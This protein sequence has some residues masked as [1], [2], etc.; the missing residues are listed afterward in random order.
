A[1]EQ[2]RAERRIGRKTGAA[3]AVD[4]RVREHVD[5]T[6]RRHAAKQERA[7]LA[8]PAQPDAVAQDDLPRLFT[9]HGGSE[10]RLAFLLGGAHTFEPAPE[11]AAER[12]TDGERRRQQSRRGAEQRTP[13]ELIVRAQGEETARGDEGDRLADERAYDQREGDVWNRAGERDRRANR[14]PAQQRARVQPGPERA[15]ERGASHRAE[16][17]EAGTG[18]HHRKRIFRQPIDADRPAPEERHAGGEED[19]RLR[20]QPD[21]FPRDRGERDGREPVGSRWPCGALIGSDS[22]QHVADD[23]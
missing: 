9:A 1:Q 4:Q 6:G 19:S 3:E 23:E 14:N 11:A 5:E 15:S 7:E 21:T 13:G 10:E 16:S 8:A 18:E 2:R 12:E 22:P 17:D 20:P